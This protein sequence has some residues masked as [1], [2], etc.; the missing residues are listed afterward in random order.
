MRASALISLGRF[1]QAIRDYDSVLRLNPKTAEAYHGRAHCY[2]KLKQYDLAIKDLAHTIEIEPENA[3]AYYLRAFAYRH[4]L[5][6]KEAI[7][8]FS[9]SIDKLP[10]M[11]HNPCSQW[12]NTFETAYLLRAELYARLKD[13][14]NAL[15][16]ISK[17]I[18]MA[19][20][21]EDK[22]YVCISEEEKYKPMKGQAYSLRAKIYADLNNYQQAVKDV[23]MSIENDPKSEGA[24]NARGSYYFEAEQ[25]GLAIDDFTK[26]LNLSKTSTRKLDNLICLAC[27]Y[28]Q[29]RNFVK[30]K[31]YFQKALELEP[32]LKHGTKILEKR[33]LVYSPKMGKVVDEMTRG[34][35]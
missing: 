12:Q 18:D 35:L 32:S 13:Y 25:Y 24:Y 29:E 5:K 30:A 34:T 31:Q 3:D 22:E 20:P 33:N 21:Q 16:D 10:K 26:A 14:P 27:A 7:S 28:Y 9:L 19:P 8:D 1:R 2:S 11:Q 17:I 6:Y 23:S 15:A 4:L